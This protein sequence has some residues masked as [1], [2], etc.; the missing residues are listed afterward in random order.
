MKL[1][2][3]STLKSINLKNRMFRSS[4]WENMASEGG[5]MNEALFNLHKDLVDGGV[6]TILTGYANVVEEEKPNLGMMGI[7]DDVFIDEYK[8]LTEMCHQSGTRIIL[9]VAYGGSMTYM[10]PASPKILAPSA[11]KNEATG[12]VPTAMSV[13]DISYLKA[14][15]VSAS[16]RAQKAGFDGVQIH[17]AHG[18]LL[19]QFLSRDYNI[20][21]DQYG[22]SIENRA[23]FLL[24]T[25][26]E[27]KKVVDPSFVV[28]TKINSEDF[29]ELGLTQQECLYVC[30]QLEKV[31]IDMIEVSGGNASSKHVLDSN[32]ACSRARVP[33]DSISYFSDFAK[34][35]VK[36]VNV[37][38]VL[39]GGNRSLQKMED[40]HNESAIP[41][42]GLSRP[43]VSEP[44]LINK[45]KE[46]KNYP[47]RCISCGKCFKE[48]K[49]C[50]FS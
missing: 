19:S 20:R 8:P 43:L 47:P 26:S 13:D 41:Y 32:L 31:G 12:V 5:H 27:I 44:D 3:K 4:T 36:V 25:I 37:P 28:M 48:G 35:L 15:F 22:G 16:L 23:R 49:N 7:Y 42:F 46:D 6:G 39:T 14:A 1:L 18:Y 33:K 10:Q 21:E 9:Q 24:E 2:E 34:K 50:I 40:L 38:I 11:V 45:W 29:T 30:E 17:S